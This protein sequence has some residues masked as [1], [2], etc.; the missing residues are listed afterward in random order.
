MSITPAVARF[1]VSTTNR[2]IT[3][4]AGAVL[5]RETAAAVGLGDAVGQHVHLKKRNRGLSEAE[6]ILGM[7]EAVAMGADCLD[8][9]VIARGDGAQ[10]MLRGFQVVHP[11]TAGAFLRRFTLGHIRQLDKALDQVHLQAFSHL[12]LTDKLTLDFD[13]SYIKSYSSRREGADPTY[14]KRY[15]LHPLFCFVSELDVCLNAKLRRSACCPEST[16][17]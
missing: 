13:S 4:Q 7:A 9:L 11:K 3:A 6:T 1:Q 15:A 2:N 8:D 14:L 16:N 12:G 5:I 17:L 10:Q